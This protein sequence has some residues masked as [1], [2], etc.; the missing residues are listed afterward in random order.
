MK[1]VTIGLMVM[2]CAL[3]SGVQ[4]QEIV[5]VDSQPIQPDPGMTAEQV[6]VTQKQDAALLTE[7]QVRV[8]APP[9][10]VPPSVV[11]PPDGELPV[12]SDD[13]SSTGLPEAE[14]EQIPQT[15]FQS[16][17]PAGNMEDGQAMAVAH[18]EQAEPAPTPEMEAAP[19]PASEAVAE[20]SNS[21]LNPWPP[22][23]PRGDPENP[24][25]VLHLSRGNVIVVASVMVCD[26]NGNC[27]CW[28]DAILGWD[29]TRRTILTTDY[30]EFLD[31][32]ATL[33]N[34]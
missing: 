20:A 5:P 28:T 17:V 16:T 32:M 23:A 29:G 27:T 11:V 6:A 19:A 14:E 15:D 22:G 4:A 18:P 25:D 10:E 8:A 21:L 24:V 34:Q 26:G 2:A 30:Q 3:A 12:E 31:L 33:G 7:M 13:P 9:V 1:K